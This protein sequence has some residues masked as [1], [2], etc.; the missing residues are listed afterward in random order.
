MKKD[1]AVQAMTELSK[2]SKDIVELK[3]MVIALSVPTIGIINEAEGNLSIVAANPD[4][5]TELWEIRAAIQEIR[6]F[7]GIGKIPKNITAI[8]NE[9]DFLME[10]ARPRKLKWHIGSSRRRGMGSKPGQKLIRLTLC[11]MSIW[12]L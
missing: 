5:A 12:S 11:A 7:F 4:L 1:C 2:L 8:R 6:D 3:Q 9:V 10:R